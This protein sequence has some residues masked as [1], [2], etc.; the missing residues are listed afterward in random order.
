MKKL[1]FIFFV[2]LT[3]ISFSQNVDSLVQSLNKITTDTAKTRLYLEIS[4]AAYLKENLGYLYK[5]AKLALDLSE[6]NLSQP[7][8]LPCRRFI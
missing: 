1:F 4:E 5:Y 3:G 7:L 2:L 6:K 8:L